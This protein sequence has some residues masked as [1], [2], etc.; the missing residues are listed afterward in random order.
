MNVVEDQKDQ[1]ET[2]ENSSTL[3]SQLEEEKGSQVLVLN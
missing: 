3:N 1:N 2:F